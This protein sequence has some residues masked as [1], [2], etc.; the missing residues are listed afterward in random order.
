M[1]GNILKSIRD[2]FSEERSNCS[3]LEGFAR[4]MPF[5]FSNL[6][7]DS[8][9]FEPEVDGRSYL[10]VVRQR[11]TMLHIGAFSNISYR[12]YCVPPQVRE[13]IKR[14]CQ[15]D[16]YRHE[17]IEADQTE[18]IVT[19]AEVAIAGLTSIDFATV[20]ARLIVHMDW[21]DGKIIEDGIGT[22]YR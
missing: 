3:V 17:L 8:V 15:Q 7:P 20:I 1:F 2:N 6:K 11:E 5:P 16:G 22:R 12:P 10:T 9:T 4:D 13:F 18:I 21:L 14:Y 19:A